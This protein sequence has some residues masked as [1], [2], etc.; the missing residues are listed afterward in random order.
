[1]AD[2][3]KIPKMEFAKALRA[4]RALLPASDFERVREVIAP[5]PHATHDRTMEGLREEDEFALL[6]ILMG[7]ATH[8]ARLDQ[9]PVIPGEYIVPDFLGR[10]QPGFSLRGWPPTDNSGFKCLIEVKSTRKN[11]FRIGGSLLRRRRRFAETFGL[12]LLFAVRFTSFSGSA[13]WVLKED[14]GLQSTLDVGV[15]DMIE[16]ARCALWDEYLY[17]IFPAVYFQASY[18]KSPRR[19]RVL[20]A[21]YGSQLA[22]QIVNGDDRMVFQ[23]TDAGLLSMFFEPFELKE[24]DCQIVG[25]TTHVLYAP[26][27]AMCSIARK[28]AMITGA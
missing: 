5:G 17:M 3:S 20:H 12:P 11:R 6:C 7:T 18:E 1:M 27:L 26:Q 14:T 15:N 10:F 23:D 13:V 22:F 16:G 2:E 21:S 28:S 4:V 24:I 9:S 19:D 25:Q 8:L